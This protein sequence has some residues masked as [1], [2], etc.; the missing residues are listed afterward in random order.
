MTAQ[1]GQGGP[2]DRSNGDPDSRSVSGRAAARLP[3]QGRHDPADLRLRGRLAGARH[4]HDRAGRRRP[5]ADVLRDRPG[6]PDP[7]LGDGRRRRRARSP[8]RSAG[9][10][11]SPSSTSR[12][13][14]P[15]TTTRMPSSSGSRR[16]PDADVQ[17]LLAEAY[18]Q[19][20]RE[21]L[22]ARRLDEIHAA[23]LAGRPSPPRRPRRA[24]SVRSAPS[25]APTCSSSRARSRAPATSPPTTTRCRWPTSR[26]TCRSRWRSATR[27]TP[28]RRSR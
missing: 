7:G 21:E 13:S 5:G 4:R 27:P 24:G 17:A 28:R 23:G 2:R 12:A 3:L 20:I 19:P 18:Q 26:A 6:D 25:T 10:A 9:S 16:P 22:I 14:R 15:A 8:A 11:G 1:A